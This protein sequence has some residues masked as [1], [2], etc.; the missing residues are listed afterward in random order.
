[1]AYHEPVIVARRELGALAQ[2][3]LLAPDLARAVRPGQYV[4]ARCAPAASD[5]PPLR[6][7]I[8]P[9]GADHA[10]GT[11]DLFLAPDERGLA[12]LA[13]QPIGAR[14]DM[15]GPLGAPF[16][17]DARTRNLLLAG[18][19]PAWPALIGLARA[20]LAR[21]AAVVLLAAAPADQ[22]PP[23]FLLPPEL[24]YQGSAEGPAALIGLLGAPAP[25]GA[26][27][28]SP[29]AWA[30]QLC[31]ALSDDLVTDA[32]NAV[33]AGRLRWARGF[34]QAAIAGPMPCGTGACLACLVETRAGLR[35]RCKDGPVFDLRDL[36]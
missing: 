36:R 29:I 9:A 34:A 26:L 33:R 28:A 12:W 1:M 13:A 21:G 30:D 8:F 5:D 11:L 2:L 25:G 14:L 19:G 4:L 24:E 31:L 17:L 15:F 18:A 7:A 6:R 3:T 10:A 23:A 35:L 27:F 20:G 22:L 16:S 32:A